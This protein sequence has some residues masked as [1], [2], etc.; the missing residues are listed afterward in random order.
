[1]KSF[2][3]LIKIERGF[4]RLRFSKSRSV[5]NFRLHSPRS[6]LITDIFSRWKQRRREVPMLAHYKSFQDLIYERSRKFPAVVLSFLYWI[7]GKAVSS[8]AP[9]VGILSDDSPNS[10]NFSSSFNLTLVLSPRNKSLIVLN[11]HQNH[12]PIT[13]FLLLCTGT[14]KMQY[15][16]IMEIS[17]DRI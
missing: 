11:F 15:F 3:Y 17:L 8:P 6:A 2:N 1:M 13:G 12:V 9:L 5:E 4:K 7:S 16:S 14:I 10:E